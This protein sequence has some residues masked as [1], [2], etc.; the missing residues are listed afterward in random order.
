MDKVLLAVYSIQIFR[1][2]DSQLPSNF[3]GGTDLLTL[4]HDFAMDV[5]TN[6][7]KP[8]TK[9][10]TYIFTC[11]DYNLPK[12]DEKTRETYGFF[13]S[14]R[15]GDSFTVAKYEK[16]GKAKRKTSVT[17]DMHST[18]DSFFYLQVPKGVGKKRAYLIIQRTDGQGIK[19]LM[20]GLLREY[21]DFL[22]LKDYRV[23]ISNLV[24]EKV[25]V[26]MMENGN[27]KQLTLTK[28]GVP[29]TIEGL[30]NQEQRVPIEN[31]TIKTIYQSNGFGS[32]WKE[33]ALQK[34][35]A[36]RQ[37]K[38]SN[39][40]SKVVVEL[41]GKPEE[42]DEVSM[43]IELDGKEKTFHLSSTSRTQPDMDVTSNVENDIHGRLR[44]DHLLD[45]AR[46]LV[47]DV[48]LEITPNDIA[49]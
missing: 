12:I 31:G 36:T 8:I 48:S 17:R 43:L 13:H 18:R 11:P 15:D 40:K 16:D 3:A 35:G 32:S 47:N 2:G 39:Q 14:G 33:W 5:L 49:S 30:R 9:K 42:Y 41:S 27:F 44:L 1:K 38:P 21:M 37:S 22:K 10:H 28:L 4:F 24:P 25:F 7:R 23:I 29:S 20:T 45:Q 34:T 6:I 19:D 26:N 46:E